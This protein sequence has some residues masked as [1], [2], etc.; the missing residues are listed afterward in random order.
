M[1]NFP[2]IKTFSLEVLPDCCL[3]AEI[4]MKPLKCNFVCRLLQHED[5]RKLTILLQ[6][7]KKSFS[8]EACYQVSNLAHSLHFNQIKFDINPNN[9]LFISCK[10]RRRRNNNNRITCSEGQSNLK[11]CLSE[12]QKSLLKRVQKICLVE[13]RPRLKSEILDSTN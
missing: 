11:L 7:G 10:R 9:I 4:V 5:F 6:K 3:P 13:K 8:I 12:I 2:I 1:K